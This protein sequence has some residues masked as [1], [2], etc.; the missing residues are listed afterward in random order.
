M[1]LRRVVRPV[2]HDC[3]FNGAGERFT[4]PPWGVFGGQPGGTGRFTVARADG[5]KEIQ[6]TKPS[7]VC[8]RPADR[9]IVETPGAGGYGDPKGRAARDIAD[10]REAGKTSAG[11]QTAHYGENDE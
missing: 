8:I 2:G 11:F 1:G 10:D 5:S 9:V 4:N 7:G 6:Q 3:D